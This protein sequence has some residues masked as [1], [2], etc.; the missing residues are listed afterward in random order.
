MQANWVRNTH[1]P[2]WHILLLVVIFIVSFYFIVFNFAF[3]VDLLF[4]TFIFKNNFLM[5]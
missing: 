2:P 3:T 5:V 1:D 4:L